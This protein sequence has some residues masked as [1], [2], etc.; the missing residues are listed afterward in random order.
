MCYLSFIN[1]PLA[2]VD[3]ALQVVDWIII[4]SLSAAS[5]AQPFSEAGSNT[6]WFCCDFTKAPSANLAYET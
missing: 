5:L 1:F 2:W 6:E 3:F 4:L